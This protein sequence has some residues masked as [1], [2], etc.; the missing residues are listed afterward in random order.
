MLIGRLLERVGTVA[1]A[2]ADGKRKLL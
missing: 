1:D 2:A